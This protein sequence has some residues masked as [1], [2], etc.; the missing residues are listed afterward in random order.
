[1]GVPKMK[2][3]LFFVSGI[4]VIAGVACF[5]IF[6]HSGA[7]EALG[8]AMMFMCFGFAGFVIA[9]YTTQ[10]TAAMQSKNETESSL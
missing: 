1:M 9:N 5:G 10:I 4:L 7:I 8:G 2:M 6:C 3:A